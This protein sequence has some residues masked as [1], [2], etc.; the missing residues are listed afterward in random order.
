L[1]ERRR[2]RE[3]LAS[4]PAAP[5]SGGETERREEDYSE[6][7]NRELGRDNDQNDQPDAARVPCAPVGHLGAGGNRVD[8]GVSLCGKTNNRIAVE[9]QT[10]TRAQELGLKQ[11]INDLLALPCPEMTD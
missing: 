4:A 7:D 11:R 5:T 3:L 9:A 10:A 8:H 2:V 1:V 6:R